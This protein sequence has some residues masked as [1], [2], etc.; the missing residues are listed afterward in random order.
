MILQVSLF[1]LINRQTLLS[2]IFIVFLNSFLLTMI[3]SPLMIIVISSSNNP[4]IDL[5]Y[6]KLFI[7]LN[8]VLFSWYAGFTIFSK[9]S[10]FSFDPVSSNYNLK[11]L[12]YVKF[13]VFCLISGFA[14]YCLTYVYVGYSYIEALNNPLQFR[15]DIIGK[16]GGYYL[17]NFSLW[18]IN[19]SLAIFLLHYFDDLRSSNKQKVILSI[20]LVFIFL[21]VIP[22][23]SRAVVLTPLLLIGFI[24]YNQKTISKIQVFYGISIALFLIGALGI[25]R[26]VAF[27]NLS[28]NEDLGSLINLI[29]E[30][31]Y[32]VIFEEI[33]ARFDNNQ[34]FY[35]YLSEEHYFE[36]SVSFFESIKQLFISIVPPSFLGGIEKGLDYDT[37]LTIYFL[38][39]QDT[40]TYGFTP[41]AEWSMNFGRKGY[42]M[43]PF[44]SGSLFAFISN[45]ARKI[46]NNMFYLIFI[47]SFIF[48]DLVWIQI[49][50]G[51]TANV[52]VFLCFNILLFFLYE[53]FFKPLKS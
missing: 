19:C 26:T 43:M 15:F 18:L 37:Y 25:Y 29:L 21:V 17:R 23:G 39:S 10:E 16:T 11:R 8:V 31:D 5:Q 12:S 47:S 13:G 41:M 1:S 27:F 2:P 3:L 42:V 44:L 6:Q 30:T 14:I 45:K 22:L 36:E 20:F 9:K 32:L 7:I 34:W 52:I 48:L 40:G 35:L 24:L 53:V 28:S 49:H 50:S 38:G 51:A 4:F 33:V 46:K